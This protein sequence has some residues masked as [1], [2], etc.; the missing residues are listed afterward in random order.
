VA[1]TNKGPLY[2]F[3]AGEELE[4]R[5]VVNPKIHRTMIGG[6]SQARFQ[7]RVGDVRMRHAKDAVDELDRPV[8]RGNEEQ[9][10]IRSHLMTKRS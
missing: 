9:Q 10:K 5:D 6:W 1:D 2:G 3:G 7:M 8:R 4:H